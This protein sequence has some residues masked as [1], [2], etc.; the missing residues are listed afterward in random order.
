MKIA[1]VYDS[2]TGNT[3]LLA[4]TIY[5]L[6]SGIDTKIYNEYSEKILNADLI[7]IGSWTDKGGP[8]DKIKLVYDKLH[9]KRVFVFGTCGF[10]GSEEYYNR[11][12]ENTKKYIQSSNEILGYYFCPGKLSMSIKEK[13]EKMLVDNPND[14]RILKM[15]DNYNNVLD[16]PNVDDLERLKDKVGKIIN[17]S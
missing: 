10:G 12:F 4:D 11:L 7:F 5:E 1:I 14:K 6:C 17:E 15:I 2:I 3:K 16:R 13:Y 9:N 8:S